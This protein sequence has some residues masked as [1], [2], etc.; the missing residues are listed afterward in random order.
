[1]STAA[2]EDIEAG[3]LLELYLKEIKHKAYILGLKNS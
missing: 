1:M 3:S 2:M